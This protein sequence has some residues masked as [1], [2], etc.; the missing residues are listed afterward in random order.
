MRAKKQLL[1]PCSDLLVRRPQY[2]KLEVISCRLFLYQSPVEFDDDDA[3]PRGG[4]GALEHTTRPTTRT[5][6]GRPRSCTGDDSRRSWSVVRSS[7]R[8]RRPG[9]RD[10]ARARRRSGDDVGNVSPT[11]R[12]AEVGGALALFREVR[13]NDFRPGRVDGGH[14]SPGDRK[15]FPI[16]QF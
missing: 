16:F 9:R 8:D 3:E 4:L 14:R 7:E 13:R 11:S 1:A 10:G 6:G 5:H 12:V 15:A 2:L